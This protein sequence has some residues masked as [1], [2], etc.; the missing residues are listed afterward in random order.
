VELIKSWIEAGAKLDA[1]ASTDAP[2]PGGEMARPER[3]KEDWTNREGKTITATLLKVEG[4]NAILLL[5]NGR[6]VPYPIENLSDESQAK[7]KAFAES[8]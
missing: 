8:R 3:V 4:N 7:V 5:E 2:A 6:S 1:D